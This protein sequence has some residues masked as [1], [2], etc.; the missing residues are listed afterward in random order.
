[1][2]VRGRGGKA[3]LRSALPLGRAGLRR[4][5]PPGLGPGRVGKIGKIGNVDVDVALFAGRIDDRGRFIL[6]D[7]LLTAAAGLAATAATATAAR[8]GGQ[9]RSVPFVG[10]VF[11]VLF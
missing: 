2:S 4:G 7:G 1:M 9:N 6:F 10:F 8:V 3:A 5:R 11:V